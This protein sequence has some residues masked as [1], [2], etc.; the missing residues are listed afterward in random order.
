MA[1]VIEYGHS[2]RV[3]VE[4]QSRGLVGQ[5]EVFIQELLHEML[6]IENTC[7]R[8]GS[9]GHP[10]H[11]FDYRGGRM[12]EEAGERGTFLLSPSHLATLALTCIIWHDSGL[13]IGKLHCLEFAPGG[14]CFA[15]GATLQASSAQALALTPS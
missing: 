14:R 2:L 13:S 15:E 3:L 6:L 9:M 12:R 7:D 4:E 8:T 10:P 5:E 11:E 1:V